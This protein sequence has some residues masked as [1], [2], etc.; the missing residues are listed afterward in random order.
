MANAAFYNKEISI[1]NT[2]NALFPAL[3]VTLALSFVHFSGLH[4]LTGYFVVAMQSVSGI[5]AKANF[6]K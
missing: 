4:S 6:K 2:Q 3:V 5:N 1:S